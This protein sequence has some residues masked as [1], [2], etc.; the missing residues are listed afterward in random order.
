MQ[1]IQA[2]SNSS[3]AADPEEDLFLHAGRAKPACFPRIPNYPVSPPFYPLF[4]P[5]LRSN[6]EM[7]R[8]RRSFFRDILDSITEN[9]VTLS[10]FDR[11]SSSHFSAPQ[12][13]RVTGGANDNSRILCSVRQC[14]LRTYSSFS[15]R[16]SSESHKSSSVNSSSTS[17]RRDEFSTSFI[18]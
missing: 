1:R 5:A 2:I 17:E 7:H 9:L 4:F 13:R 14:V 16:F 11:I 15:D 8:D 12:L 3:S 18:T 10:T 6:A